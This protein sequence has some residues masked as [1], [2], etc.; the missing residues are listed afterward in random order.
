MT[1][2]R[3]SGC[4][5]SLGD[6]APRLAKATIGLVALGVAQWD[7]LLQGEELAYLGSEAARDATTAP[8]PDDL[9]PTLRDRL[10]ASGVTE[11]YSHQAT[12]WEAAQ[13]GEH[14]AI[15]TG[16]AS[17]KSLAFNLPV[18]AALTE[19]P[20]HRALYLYPTKALA[21]DQ[22]RALGGLN[23][24]H[25]RAAIYDGDTESERRWQVRKWSN[26]VL[27]NPDMLHV[28]VLPHHDRWGDVLSNLRYVVVD[29]A[30][31][32][33]GVFGSHV[34][35]VLRR[36]RRLA[37]VYGADP[38]FLLASAT[39]ANPG[40]LALALTGL[41]FTVIGADGAPKTERTV[42]LWN[43]PLV[44]EELGQRASAL[45]E[46]S[47]LMA[48]LV[49]RGLRTL[50]FAK[51]RRSAELIHKFTAD[52]LGD[53]SRLSPYRAGYTAAQRRE[54][55]QRLFAG[56]LLGVSATN[57]LE[58]GIDVGMLDAVIS[59]GFPGTVASLRQQW[60]RA[61]RRDHGLTVLVA[62]E[63]A[64]A[65]RARGRRCIRGSARRR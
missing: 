47:K 33:R 12:A 35:N 26:L 18:L 4:V 8:L 57:A 55:E 16:T 59:V 45:A 11:L 5:L 65:R 60:G 22:V 15:T 2:I 29:E 6:E 50:V 3:F 39:I 7:D 25:I 62:S 42:A 20:K 27:T 28:G 41:D 9:P 43:P 53:S 61:G 14:I 51:S 64:R 58:L 1:R 49:E 21:Q 19:Q 17:G 37:R 10:E 46:A 31:V 34:G 36:L 40:E 56:E 32:Y 13:R 48:D 54:I 63:D 24:K 52:R 44:D 30:H 38:Q 23:V